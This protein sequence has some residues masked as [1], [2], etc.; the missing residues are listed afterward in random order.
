MKKLNL[1]FIQVII[2]S[3]FL[4]SCQANPNIATPQENIQTA[5]S[6]PRTLT[7]CLGYEPESLYL[8]SVK[9][10]AAWAVL[11]AI[12]DGPI[13]I[14]NY[15]AEPVILDDLPS[16][17]NGEVKISAVTVKPGDPIVD[18]HGN[19]ILL[20]AGALVYPHGCVETSCAIRWDGKS[21]LEMDQITADF[22]LKPGI[23]WSDGKPLTAQDS[24]YSFK[25]ASDSATPIDKRTIQQTSSY[26]QKNEQIIEWKGKPGLLTQSFET[27]FWLPLPK[28]IWD[29]Y[30][31]KELLSVEASTKYP[32]GWGAYIIDQWKAGQ[33]ISLKKNPNYFRANEGLPKFDRLVF[34]FINKQGDTNIM[35]VRKSECD[36]SN[37]TTLML[38]Q[39]ERLELFLK[40]YKIP[41]NKAFFGIGPL[42]EYLIFNTRDSNDKNFSLMSNIKMRQ[43]VSYCADLSGIMKSLFVKLFNAPISLLTEKNPYYQQGLRSYE[44]ENSIDQGKAIL[45]QLGWK[46]KDGNSLS[47]RVAENINGYV[48]G[49]PLTV[50]YLTNDSP[51]RKTFSELIISS[52]QK[53]GFLV[54][55]TILKTYDFLALDSRFWKGDFDLAEFAW[56]SGKL[57]PC[58]LF[59]SAAQK[60]LDKPVNSPNFNVGGY[61]NSKFDQLCIDSLQPLVDETTQQ[62]IQFELQTLFNQE[63]PALPIF[64]YFTADFARPD[65]CPFSNDVSARSDLRDIESLDFGSQCPP[66]PN[67]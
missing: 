59:S 47:P 30:T 55:E 11:E 4:S 12:Y 2:I 45:D 40:Y 66:I 24:I 29:K 58:F 26:I 7:I 50:R 18:I 60:I 52:L 17:S 27:Y 62:K 63:L 21:K 15:Q 32:I 9:T 48:N 33:F 51:W 67:R 57:S 22:R 16:F 65:F 19:P 5:N 34:K 28:H 41:E 38:D 42:T 61:A 23:Q 44:T 43:A 10:Q 35:A 8:Y 56:S 64:S 49:T 36:L 13:D 3:A 20:G 46:E 37:Q 54:E 6:T 53:C 31:A 39:A 1:F 25:I 14:R